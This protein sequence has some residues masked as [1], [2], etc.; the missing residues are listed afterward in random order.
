VSALRARGPL[1]ALVLAL[2][3]ATLTHAGAEP[4]PYSL[5]VTVE[6]GTPRGPESFR[7][8]LERRLVADLE[9]QRCFASVGNAPVEDPGPGD[10]RLFVLVDDFA[11]ETDYDT[12]LADRYDP[13]VDASR[14][15]TVRLSADFHAELE[16]AAEDL[17]VRRREFHDSASF[18][19]LYHEDPRDGARDKLIAAVARTTRKLLCKGSAQSWAEQI[20]KVRRDG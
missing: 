17:L 2:G 11:E 14:L 15:L 3:S 5:A 10:L 6:W 13:Q 16:L 12:G 4:L 9:A 8:E 1:L 20:A 18:R 7:A 19:P